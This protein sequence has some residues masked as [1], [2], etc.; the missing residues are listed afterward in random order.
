MQHLMT[1][2]TSCWLLIAPSAL[3]QHLKASSFNG[4]PPQLWG[5]IKKLT[6]SDAT[7]G[8]YF[9]YSVAISGD[10]LV[11]GVPRDQDA[12][13]DSGSAYIFDRDFGGPNNWGEV[14]KL[15]ASDAAAGDWFGSAVSIS[16]DIV[17]IGAHEDDNSGGNCAGSAYVFERDHE[18]TD[19]WGE[20]IKLTASDP[21]HFDLFGETVGISGDT[22][23]VG[24]RGDD[25]A[26]S[27]SG[28]AYVFE[29]NLGGTDNWDERIKL[30]ASDATASDAFGNSV[31]ISGDTLVIG[32]PGNDD[33][34]DFSGSAYVFERDHHGADAWG[35]VRK[36]TASDATTLDQFGWA[37]SIDED[38]VAIG[39][40]T[41]DDTGFAYVFERN[42][43]GLGNWGEVRKLVASDAVVEDAFGYSVSISG[44]T[45][46]VGA[47]GNDDAGN[48]SGSAYIFERDL[49]GSDN[50]GEAQKIIASDTAA[51]DQFGRSLAMSGDTL[52]V[53]VHQN[54]D[55][56]QQSGSAYVFQEQALKISFPLPVPPS[57]GSFPFLVSINSVFD[58]SMTVPFCADE[59][60][61][62]V[63]FTGEE[64]SGKYGSIFVENFGC[65]D[66]H[67]FKNMTGSE[68]VINGN[69]TGGGTP[70]FLSYESHP[71]YDFRTIDQDP[72]GEIDV[73]AVADGEVTCVGC[74]CPTG[75]FGAIQLDHPG[76]LRTRY[77]HLSAQDVALGQQ[78]TRG[79]VIGTSG[80]VGS[81]GFPHLHFEV[82]RNVGGKFI[83]VDPYGWTGEG[84]DP[85]THAENVYLWNFPFP[86]FIDGFESGD[87][88]A[89]SQVTPSHSC[90]N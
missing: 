76:G 88:C 61:R 26:G 40:N 19:A 66:L 13:H 14:A 57:R 83:H 69:Y 1:I 75:C 86:I 31:S 38:I 39:A 74:D 4:L 27:F 53:G 63:A 68:F 60:D 2:L 67:G 12:G 25:D 50:W 16:G 73:L 21:A 34:G 51:D 15:T 90:P 89:W 70:E 42:L 37:V 28:S 18:G 22:L 65:G 43:G 56:G 44:D 47:I 3:A 62:V 8:D 6:A 82:Q 55:V 33:A 32:A 79:E 80:D 46:V 72:S 54:D 9:G 20:R 81:P 10:T 17:V 48:L 64:G 23:V 11:V 78:V 77:L 59:D 45:L 29:R 49:G 36:I 7:A 24:A 71:G 85:Y 52:I 5:E 58:H 41:G 35:E 87:P 30:T 84:D